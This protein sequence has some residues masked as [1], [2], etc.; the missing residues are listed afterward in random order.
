MSLVV[1]WQKSEGTKTLI[2]CTCAISVDDIEKSAVCGYLDRKFDEQ[3]MEVV[4][5]SDVSDLGCAPM[6]PV[7]HVLWTSQGR[8]RGPGTFRNTS[9][10]ED[11]RSPDPPRARP[12]SDFWT[13]SLSWQRP[14]QR[15]G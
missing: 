7:M 11:L 5:A 13:V 3:I 4:H 12:V 10:G 6:W 1:P 15:C 8:L 2:D 9:T 14:V